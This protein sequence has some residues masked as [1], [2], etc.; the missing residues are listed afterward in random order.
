MTRKTILSIG[1]DASVF[2]VDSQLHKRFL[3]YDSYHTFTLIILKV[4]Q[5]QEQTIGSSRVIQYGGHNVVTTFLRTLFFTLQL[6]ARQKYALVTTQD[7]LYSGV[8]GYLTARLRRLPLYVQLHGDYLDNERWFKSQVGSFNRV[9]NVVGKF[10]LKRADRIRVVS[11]RLK[12]QIAKQ[13]K[14]D[15]AKIISIPIGTDM[16]LFVPPA[17]KERK[18]IIAFAQ[19][20][21]LE[22]Q[23]LLFV[24]VTTAVMQRVPDATVV[25]AGDGV[26]KAEMQAAY[27]SAGLT[28]RVTFLDN[29][30]Q[31]DLVAVYQ[32]AK[33]Y[34]H[35]ADWE[36]WGMP[37]IEAMA[38]GCPVVTTDT[39]C[40]GEAVKHEETGLV[41]PIN[42]TAA[43]STA[44]ERLLTDQALWHRLSKRGIIEAHEWSFVALARK[45]MEWYG[46]SY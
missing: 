40:A 19:R 42:D 9:M 12:D 4:G 27:A 35:T 33:C 1:T 22:K 29:V 13:Q 46:S 2:E 41:T 5:R 23:P 20:L 15:P 39:G 6:S 14:I 3:V 11:L 34:L 37:M 43:L 32:T 45:N 8:I 36:G 7:V 28:N 30:E 21:I 26:L 44:V 16:S 24:A 10:I 17:N 25:I 38:A 18:P 31:S